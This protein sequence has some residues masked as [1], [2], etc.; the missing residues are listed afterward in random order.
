MPFFLYNPVSVL[1][2]GA[3]HHET[4]GSFQNITD[5]ENQRPCRRFNDFRGYPFIRVNKPLC[6]F[7][8]QEFHN[9]TC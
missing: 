5:P 4:K 2:K 6:L 7:L 3:F 1:F 9:L 8:Q